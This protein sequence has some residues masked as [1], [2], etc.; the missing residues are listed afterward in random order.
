MLGQAVLGRRQQS[1][2]A[3]EQTTCLHAHALEIQ[4]VSSVISEGDFKSYP[5]ACLHPM[6][7]C[8]IKA[9]TGPVLW[10]QHSAA[11][12]KKVSWDGSISLH[13]S[14]WQ[15][16]FLPSEVDDADPAVF[17]AAVLPVTQGPTQLCTTPSLQYALT[18]CSHAALRAYTPFSCSLCSFKLLPT[19]TYTS[20]RRLIREMRLLISEKLLPQHKFFLCSIFSR[21]PPHSHGAAVGMNGK[22][23]HFQSTKNSG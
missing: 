15:G 22:N 1:F 14:S 6:V 9:Q 21:E 10:Q 17:P 19:S 3:Q 16:A 13:L 8:P 23:L 18:N 11:K 4:L 12:C 2:S 20:S 7:L 5:S